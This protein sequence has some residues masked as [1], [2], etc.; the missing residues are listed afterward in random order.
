MFSRLLS[1]RSPEQIGTCVVVL[2]GLLLWLLAA[3]GPAQA[4]RFHLTRYKAQLAGV[5]RTDWVYEHASQGR[6]D[7]S[8]DGNGFQSTQFSTDHF[9]LWVFGTGNGKPTLA[10]GTNA[11]DTSIE[12][13]RA[14]D[15]QG[16]V[17]S[18]GVPIDCTAGNGGEGPPPAPDCGS[19][20]IGSLTARLGYEKADRIELSDAGEAFSASHRDLY[21]NC[22]FF[23]TA[24]VGD[25]GDL[26]PSDADLPEPTLLDYPPCRR[27]S[28]RASRAWPL[29]PVLRPC[30]ASAG[31]L[32][33]TASAGWP[34][35]PVEH[36]HCKSYMARAGGARVGWPLLP[37]GRHILFTCLDNEITISVRG[38]G[39][40][41]ASDNDV[42]R[43]TKIDWVLTLTEPI[44]YRSHPPRPQFQ[45]A[46]ARSA[47]AV[48]SR[49]TAW[50]LL[51]VLPNRT[52]C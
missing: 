12:T 37:L 18:G 36:G 21:K 22:P 39:C 45:T 15:R 24:N 50:P 4:T 9:F 42:R 14:V 49:A 41:D 20:T 25:P 35:I 51:P 30:K 33:Q 7:P 6:C 48:A 52:H 1:H 31:H 13:S 32:A 28:A 29:V 11:S 40:E 46:R 23:G 27:H 3:A 26:M 2:L 47:D 8:F 19:R 34:L 44:K 5:E 43:A 10:Y 17:T 38:Q 16:T